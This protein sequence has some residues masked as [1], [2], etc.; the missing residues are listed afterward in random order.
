ML[1]PDGTI[2]NALPEHIEP[3]FT[4]IVG[5]VKTVIVLIA[6][7]ILTQPRELVPLTE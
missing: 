7:L 2:V 3:L 5:S 6:G 4:L 1:A